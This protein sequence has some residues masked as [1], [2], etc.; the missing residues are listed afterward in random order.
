VGPKW[1]KSVRQG[2][3]G[4]PWPSHLF[5][6]VP[7]AEVDDAQEGLGMLL[8]DTVLTWSLS[9]PTGG[10]CGI[11]YPLCSRHTRGQDFPLSAV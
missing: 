6:G 10:G 2:Q 1:R 7:D 9:L 4:L 3:L 5:W 8:L 11:A